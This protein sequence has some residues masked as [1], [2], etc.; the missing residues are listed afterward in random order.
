MITLEEQQKLF[1]NVSKKLKKKMTVYAVGGTAMTLLGIKDTTLDI[2]IVFETNED[3]E[4]FKEAIISIGY[5]PIDPIKIY[6]IKRDCPEML[7]L[8]ES[9]F[10][11]FVI[12]VIGFIFSEKS[13][14]IFFPVIFNNKFFSRR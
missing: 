5:Q 12:N 6:G 10:D 13:R 8:D 14:P 1:L 9:R 7:T 2:D 4:A 11:L 3:R